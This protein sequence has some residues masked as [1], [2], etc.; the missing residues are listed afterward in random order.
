MS[1]IATV[2]A[3][4]APVTTMAAMVIVGLIGRRPISTTQATLVAMGL[5]WRPP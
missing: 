1:A 3:V 4:V 5:R 2:P